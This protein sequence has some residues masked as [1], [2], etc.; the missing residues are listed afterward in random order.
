MNG[1]SV[2]REGSTLRAPCHVPQIHDFVI[3]SGGEN[4]AI[5]AEGHRGDSTGIPP[6]RW[7]SPCGPG[8]P[9]NLTVLSPLAEARVLRRD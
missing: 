5:R 3:T 6:E 7:P 2:P 4:L 8:C 9:H 1:I